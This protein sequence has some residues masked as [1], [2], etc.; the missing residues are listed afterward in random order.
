MLKKI[1]IIGGLDKDGHTESIQRLEIFPGQVLAVAGPTGS[2]KTQL[3]ADI[4]QYREGDS[5]TGR[6]VLIEG[7]L[8]TGS[9]HHLVAEVSQKMNFIIDTT[10]EAFLYRHAK[11]R[12]I[13]NPE[14]V[15]GTVLAVA[16]QLAGE[17]VS[18]DDNL[19]T[20]SGG[21]ARALMVG[22]V[23]LISR[24]PVVLVDEIENAGIDR[25]SAM[26]ILSAHGKIV[27]VVTHDPTLMLMAGR[28]VI[29]KNG[30]MHKLYRNTPLENTMME[31]LAVM[32]RDM[33]RL[34]ETLRSG[35]QIIDNHSKKE[36]KDAWQAFFSTARSI[37][38]GLSVN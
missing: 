15:I 27:L 30:G 35:R 4:E 13:K 28:R 26:A 1:T 31:K 18:L 7:D 20:L 9:S 8:S 23:A 38:A 37:S 22:D 17:P 32:E 29:M 2:G 19:T 25:L 36:T 12:A 14:T 21:Q 5:P 6:R 24:A 11:V 3:I 34:R 16:N 10:V 33:S